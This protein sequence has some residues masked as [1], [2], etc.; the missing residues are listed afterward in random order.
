MAFAGIANA[1]MDALKTRRWSSSVFRIFKKDD[2][3]NPVVS[4]RNKW[5]NG[6]P[7]QGERF[8]GS[9]T[10]LVWITDA[11]HFLKMITIVSIC[12]SVIT[13]VPLFNWCV[14]LILLLLAFTLSFE[15]FYGKILRDE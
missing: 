2:W 8:F 7:I 14:D 12:L 5:K 9:S 13:Y 11:W 3:F 10:F 1:C 4:W 15:L 6:D